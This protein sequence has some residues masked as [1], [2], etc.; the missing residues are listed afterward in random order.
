MGPETL[1]PSLSPNGRVAGWLA[2]AGLLGACASAPKPATESPAS[3]PEAELATDRRPE[4]PH[5]PPVPEDVV[6]R[7][8]GPVRALRLGDGAELTPAELAREL[9]DADAVCAGERHGEAKQHYAE[10]W[11][12]ELLADRARAMRLELGLGLEMFERRHTPDL[13]LFGA[14]RIDEA[15]LLERTEY[16]KTWG[17]PFAYYRPLLARARD[18]RVAVVGLNAR[19]SLVRRIAT[20]GL[21]G[22]TDQ[23]RYQLPELDLGDTEH[24][25]EFERRM[26][27]HPGRAPGYYAAQVV[28]DETMADTAARWVLAH[29]PVRRLLAVAGQ[30]H[31]HRSAI[32]L[33]AE[34]RGLV[35]VRA[36]LLASEKPSP[37]AARGYDYAL[38]VD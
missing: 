2:L 21:D 16:E 11:L 20:V 26:Q 19:R 18:L 24:L 4:R 29:T 17:F 1:H 22:L 28:W 12:L 5:T 13:A 31:C 36:V 33:R 38:I 15:E 32:P 14:F 7:A 10:L 34:R 37:E 27:N 35:S 9:L 3:L 30:A 23:E 25:A 6:A 8:A